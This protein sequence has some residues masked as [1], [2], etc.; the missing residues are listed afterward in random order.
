MRPG[1][2]GGG[3]PKKEPGAPG[4]GMGAA[5]EDGPRERR[6]QGGIQGLPERLSTVCTWDVSC[7][8]EQV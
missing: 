3:K 7:R 1:S 4:A 6:G 2:Q 8:W 5:Q